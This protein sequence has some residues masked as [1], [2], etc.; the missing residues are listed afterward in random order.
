MDAVNGGILELAPNSFEFD[1]L[2]YYDVV[3]ILRNLVR[4]SAPKKNYGQIPLMKRIN[5]FC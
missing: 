5:S 1:E 3:N 4:L 2:E